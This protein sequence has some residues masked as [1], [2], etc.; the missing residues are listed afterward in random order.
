VRLIAHVAA[1]QGRPT[2]GFSPVDDI[3]ECVTAVLRE[4]M[5]YN[6]K[7]HPRRR[8]RSVLF[9]VFGTGQAKQDPA[10]VVDQLVSAALDFL[11]ADD[12][13]GIA[14]QSVM[15]LAHTSAQ[16]EQL[17]RE[18]DAFPG[19]IRDEAASRRTP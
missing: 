10:R 6:R 15:F 9:P 17:E 13:D 18:L 1:V 3:G 16:R 5:R 11:S 12:H 4:V 7:K 19:L 2:R 8:L 14:P